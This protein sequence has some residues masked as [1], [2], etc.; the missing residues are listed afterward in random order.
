MLVSANMDVPIAR[1]PRPYRMRARAV[2]KAETGRRILRA[3]LDLHIERF[4]DQ[5]TL[6]D[7]AERAGVTVQ[8]VIRRFGSRERLIAAAAEHAETQVLQQRDAAPVGDVSGAVENLLDHYEEWGTSAL[9]L[10]AQEDRVP[11][12]RVI[13]DRGRA[14]H[15]AWVDRTFEP[16]LRGPSKRVQRAQLITLTDVYVWKLLHLD[17]GLDRT[18]AATALGEMI[19][20]VLGKGK[21]A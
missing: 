3:V 20:A 7:I 21:A 2:A 17:L 1:Q 4:H 12:L 14:A 8:T 9:R 5:I 18:E 13:A 15:Y 16:Y 19:R 11:Q 6:E 10:L